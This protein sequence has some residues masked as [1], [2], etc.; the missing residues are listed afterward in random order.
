MFPHGFPSFYKRSKRWQISNQGKKSAIIR[1]F[2]QVPWDH[3]IFNQLWDPNHF[4]RLLQAIP[5]Q[6]VFEW[7]LF[8]GTL[9]FEI[10]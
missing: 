8:T 2:L 4:L 5:S 10:W 9:R 6:K 1:V 3:K 7:H